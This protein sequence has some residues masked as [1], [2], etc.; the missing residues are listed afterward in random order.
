M[1][2]QHVTLSVEDKE[3]LTS[4][5]S[6]GSLKVRV[7]KR[8]LALKK[9]DSGMSYQSVSKLLEVSYPT[10]LNWAKKYRTTGLEFLQDKA[11]S[12][13]PIKYDGAAA[14]KVTALACSQPPE[15]HARWSLRLLS[16][17]VVELEIL[18]E[19]TYSQVGRILKKTNFSHIE[20]A[21]GVLGN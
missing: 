7:Q 20:N 18:P 19:M 16:D 4:L 17:R 2:K 6:K 15:G 13:R 10:I 5:L 21:N 12:G 3:Y 1:K 8:A 14:S 9:L 11:R